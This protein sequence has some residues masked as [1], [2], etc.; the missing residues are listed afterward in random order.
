MMLTK[1]SSWCD[2]CGKAVPMSEIT[3]VQMFKRETWDEIDD[4]LSQFMFCE[5][6]ATKFLNK[7][8]K[9][10]NEQKQEKGE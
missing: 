7:I 4:V 10:I 3:F 1:P 9:A 8:L 2:N 5:L 6:C